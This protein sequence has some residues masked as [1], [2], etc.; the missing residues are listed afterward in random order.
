MP[1]A[2]GRVSGNSQQSSGAPIPRESLP[3]GWVR[4]QYGCPLACLVG[5]FPD[6]CRWQSLPV[7]Y[8]LVEQ[9]DKE[10]PVTVLLAVRVRW[11]GVTFSGPMPLV[12]D[13]TLTGPLNLGPETPTGRGN[14]W[15]P[16]ETLINLTLSTFSLGELCMEPT[17]YYDPDS[18]GYHW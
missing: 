12:I 14:R 7:W 8:Q 3:N 5:H 17:N 13:M 11:L 2:R 9:G 18:K 15:K 16:P 1:R 4:W 6:Q 10:F